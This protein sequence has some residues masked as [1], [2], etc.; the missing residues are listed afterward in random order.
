V[1]ELPNVVTSPHCGG[2]SA[3]SNLAMSRM[4]TESVLA[5]LAGSPTGAIANPDVLAALR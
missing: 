5:A 3:E 1:T 4:A 2:I